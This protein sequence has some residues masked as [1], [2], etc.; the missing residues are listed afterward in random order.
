MDILV[1]NWHCFYCLCVVVKN[2]K[3]HTFWCHC[4]YSVLLT[5]LLYLLLEHP[6]TNTVLKGQFCLSI[7]MK[8]VWL[9]GYPKSMWRTSR[10][11]RPHSENRCTEGQHGEQDRCRVY[12]M[13]TPT[14]STGMIARFWCGKRLMLKNGVVQTRAPEMFKTPRVYQSWHKQYM[15]MG[16]ADTCAYWNWGEHVYKRLC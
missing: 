6:Y 5:I 1:C 11:P 8:I 9:H 15:L 13:H 16:T 12:S 3:T 14:W 7:I 2:T 10:A 4:L